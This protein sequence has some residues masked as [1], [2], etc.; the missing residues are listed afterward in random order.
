M[1]LP[2][3]YEED[4]L[5]FFDGKP[6]ELA[7]YRALESC[8]EAELPGTAVKVQKTQISLY[9]RHLYAAVSLPRGK[10]GWPEHCLV[11]TLGL[12]RRLDPPRAVM[13]VEPWPGRWTNHVPLSREEE[14]DGELLAWLREAWDFAESK[15]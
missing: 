1:R 13:T 2:E 14:L 15:R 7:L 12:P 4:L 8:L 10:R 11:L 3:R 5:F 6:R 9:G